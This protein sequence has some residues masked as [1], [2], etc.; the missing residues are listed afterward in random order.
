MN[1][2]EIKSLLASVTVDQVMSVYSGKANRCYCGCAGNHRYAS[3]H[4]DAAAKDRGY[5]IGKEEVND[6]QVKKALGIVQANFA[7]EEGCPE[8]SL[9]Y[10][11]QGEDGAS[12]VTHFTAVVGER[13]Y[14]VYLLPN[15]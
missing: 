4:I 15:A 1:V 13:S 11:L 5:A 6:R 8:A 10:N 3:K 2:A 14:T 12:F 7:L 9:P